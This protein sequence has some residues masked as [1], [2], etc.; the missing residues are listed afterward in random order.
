MRIA[1][2]GSLYGQLDAF[3]DELSKDKRGFDWV[4]S[5]GNLGVWPD[6]LRASRQAR[7]S[8]TGPGNFI[9]YLVGKRTIPIPTLMVAG[10]HDDH[11][12]IHRMVREGYG[13]LCFNLHFLVNGNTT[14]L[15][16]TDDSIKV[17]GLGGTYSPNPWTLE[18]NYT[19]EQVRTSCAAGPVDLLLT[20]EG[21]DGE[22]F[23]TVQSQAKGINKICY[24]TRPRLLVHGKYKESRVYRTRQTSTAAICLGNQSFFE[25][26]VTKKDINLQP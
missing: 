17:L 26:D 25:L 15:E 19:M 10:K 1:L 13:E 16:T 5:T 18:G 6:P 21:P 2:V 23:G 11:L 3:Y 14:L 8:P 12:W 24:A 4:V 22:T 9:D 7:N 20:H